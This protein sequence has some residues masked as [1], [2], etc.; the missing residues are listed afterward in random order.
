M[1]KCSNRH[2]FH[3]FGLLI[4]KLM[5][6]GTQIRIPHHFDADLDPDSQHWS[7]VFISFREGSVSASIDQY[8]TWK[9]QVLMWH[10]VPYVGTACVI[11]DGYR[12]G[13]HTISL[14]YWFLYSERRWSVLFMNIRRTQNFSTLIR[15]VYRTKRRS[16]K[17]LKLEQRCQIPEFFKRS[18]PRHCAV[19]SHSPCLLLPYLLFKGLREPSFELV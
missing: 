15:T 7:T 16:K 1:K 5:R 9:P 11:K 12:T 18:S 14:I 6:I 4:C 17:Y 10:S 2:I 19:S 13:Y 3:N 8:G